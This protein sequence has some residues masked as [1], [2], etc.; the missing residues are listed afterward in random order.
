LPPD[1]IA[2]QAVNYT[3]LPEYPLWNKMVDQ[4]K[5]LSF[6]FEITARCN[7]NC[8]HCYIN[9]AANDCYA[10]ARELS[11]EEID[12]ITDEAKEMGVLWCL[13]SGGEPLLRKDFREIYLLLKRKGFLV[14]IFTNAT[15]I[16][17]EMATLFKKYPP[18][19]IEISIYGVTETTYEKVTRKKGSFHGLMRGLK[20]LDDHGVPY[21]LK[22]IA[23][24]SNVHEMGDIAKFCR[25]RSATKY[26]FD[27]TLHLRYDRDSKRNDEIREERLGPEMIVSLERSDS[28]RFGEMEQKCDRLISTIGGDAQNDHV[29]LC[30][31]GNGEFTISYDGKL[32][33]C[34]SLCSPEFVYDTRSGS[35]TIAEAFSQLVNKVRNL[36]TKNDNFL[37]KCG[38][39]GIKNLCLCCPAHAWLETG[40]LDE[41]VDY[42]CQVAHARAESL[43]K[44][45]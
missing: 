37:N 25:E 38:N 41:A 20:R 16:T 24:K 33:L 31:P 21:S 29:F 45:T 22:A 19:S 26:R 8:R 13:I 12:R 1:K 43:L 40:H 30:R 11:M 35:Q 44:E 6:S 3:P 14:G 18:R 9:L 42:F 4:K 36:R 23:M 32:K 10:I 2:D 7:N 17:E 5:I 27:T 39:C 15:L 28:E 34:S